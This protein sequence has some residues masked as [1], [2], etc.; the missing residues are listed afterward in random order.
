MTAVLFS[1]PCIPCPIYVAQGFVF[2]AQKFPAVSR[3]MAHIQSLPEWKRVDY[4]A[5]AIIKGWVRHGA[6][7]RTAA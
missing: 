2:D 6:S 5:E 7:V 1:L 3:Y 4:G